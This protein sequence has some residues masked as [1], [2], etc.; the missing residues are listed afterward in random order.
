MR[1]CLRCGSNA[2]DSRWSCPAC[3]A[4]PELRDGFPVFAP[5]LAD[6]DRTEDADYLYAEI[7]AAE[8][9][10]FWFRNRARLIAW[11]LRRHFPTARSFF[12]IGCGTGY[13]LSHLR[14]VSPGLALV[15]SDTRVAALQHA[16]RR[17]PEV[18]LVQMD[19]RHAP[20]DSEFDVVGAFDVVEHLSNDGAALAALARTARPGGGVL[21]MVPQHPR[22]WSRL[23][24]LSGHKRRYTRSD[25]VSKVRAAGLLLLTATSFSS[26]V[27]PGL[28][29]SRLRARRFEADLMA[30]YRYSPLLGALLEGVFAVERALIEG[31][32]RFPV[33]GS[34][35]L[36]A[37][38][39]AA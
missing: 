14:H 11:A 10:H 15:G 17:L 29:L 8:P 5:R 20:F 23:D 9:R 36:V 34:L 25:L 24:E 22:L 37:R 38:R 32:A 30:E 35:L 21:I 4:A 3:G 31:G 13:I 19:I 26:L 33:G 39:P 18:P 16:R 7:A 1:V 2:V 12:E 27:L 28:L 6:G